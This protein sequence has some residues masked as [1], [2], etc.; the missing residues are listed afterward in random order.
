MKIFLL[1]LFVLIL[2]SCA[3]LK[4][5]ELNDKNKQQDKIPLN[6][7]METTINIDK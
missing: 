2:T 6:V 4:K 3:S 5:T 1:F 7:T